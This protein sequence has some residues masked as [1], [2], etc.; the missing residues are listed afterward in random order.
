MPDSGTTWNMNRALSFRDA[1]AFNDL[2]FQTKFYLFPCSPALLHAILALSNIKGRQK[3]LPSILPYYFEGE[4]V[5][6]HAGK[7]NSRAKFSRAQD[8]RP[9]QP[10]PSAIYAVVSMFLPVKVPGRACALLALKS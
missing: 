6:D 8:S 4:L 2:V 3:T 7:R 10:G 1:L 9:V 5:R